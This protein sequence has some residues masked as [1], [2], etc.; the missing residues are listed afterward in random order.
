MTPVWRAALLSRNQAGPERFGG[1]VACALPLPPGL[2]WCSDA[3]GRRPLWATRRGLLSARLVESRE[4]I[5]EALVS[6]ACGSSSFSRSRSFALAPFAPELL[7]GVHEAL[8]VE[9]ALHRRVQ[10]ERARRPLAGEL[11]ALRVAEAVLA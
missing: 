9:R 8:R 7:A 2:R 1:A 5:F 6:R 4:S 10:L 3:R 11:P